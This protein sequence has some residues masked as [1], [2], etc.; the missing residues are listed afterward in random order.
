[1]AESY[2]ELLDGAFEEYYNRFRELNAL[3]KENAVTRA[4]LFP[5]GETLIDADRMHKMLS[6]EI[7]KRVGMNRYWLDEKRAADGKGVLKQRVILI[8]IALVVGLAIGT[9]SRMGVLDF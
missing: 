6:M 1:M 3:S 4:E 9:L 2:K 5:N 7:V 8:V